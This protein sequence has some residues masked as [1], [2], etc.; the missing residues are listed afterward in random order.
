[1]RV[2]LE[3]LNVRLV[4]RGLAPIRTG[5]G[6]HTGDVV[7]GNIG[8]EQRMEYTVIGDAVHLAARLE[9]ATKELVDLRGISLRLD[10]ELVVVDVV[11]AKVRLGAEPFLDLD[12]LFPDSSKGGKTGHNGLLNR[13]R[14]F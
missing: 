13:N 10:D 2:A 8:C 14:S 6:I 11:Y 4:E 12:K 1:M 9:S 7:A 5:I 3:K